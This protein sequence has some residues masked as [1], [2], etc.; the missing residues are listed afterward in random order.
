M[1]ANKMTVNN[2]QEALVNDIND[3]I[4]ADLKNI[5]DHFF[6]YN[7]EHIFIK[8]LDKDNAIG[9]VPDPGSHMIESD[10]ASEEY[11]QY[12]Y[13]ITTRTKLRSDAYNKLFELSQYFQV[14]NQSKNLNKDDHPSIFDKDDHPWIF[15]SNYHSESKNLNKVNGSPWT[16]DKIEV[17]NGPNAIQEDLQGTAMYAMDVAVFIYKNKGVL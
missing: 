12:N 7:K 10:M 3:H 6:T 16:F 8:F 11:W 17:P 15:N 1:T 5:N 2:L 13:S 14:L 4:D 9:L